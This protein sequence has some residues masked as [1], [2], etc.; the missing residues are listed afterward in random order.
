MSPIDPVVLARQTFDELDWF[1]R[2]CIWQGGT[3][4]TTYEDNGEEYC[5]ELRKLVDAWAAAE[6]QKPLT[7]T[8]ICSISNLCAS[9]SKT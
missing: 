1:S 8:L 4:F 2:W 5:A 6:K 9:V 7:P 3:A